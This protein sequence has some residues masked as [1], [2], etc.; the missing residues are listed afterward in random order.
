MKYLHVVFFLLVSNLMSA[1]IN[2]IFY[3]VDYSKKYDQTYLL[4]GRYMPEDKEVTLLVYAYKG[5]SKDESDLIAKR[6]V[7]L[8]VPLDS[9]KATHDSGKIHNLRTEF[10]TMSTLK[11]TKELTFI[12][13]YQLSLAAVKKIYVSKTQMSIELGDELFLLKRLNP[14]ETDNEEKE[15]K[16]KVRYYN[17]E[18]KKEI[19]I[20]DD[21][22]LSYFDDGK[23]VHTFKIKFITQDPATSLSE[24]IRRYKIIDSNKFTNVYIQKNNKV[25]KMALSGDYRDYLITIEANAS[26]EKIRNRFNKDESYSQE[27]SDNTTKQSNVDFSDG[28]HKFTSEKDNS[29]TLSITNDKIVL[30]SENDKMFL[31]LVVK[32]V[33]KFESTSNIFMRE[34][35]VVENEDYEYMKLL[36]LTSLTEDERE[37]L[38]KTRS[39]YAIVLYPKKDNE[40]KYT[41]IN[42]IYNG[43]K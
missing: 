24:N 11:K 15:I 32:L 28:Y 18:R 3:K 2:S 40:D 17:D 21:K 7:V 16:G 39:E 23:L 19:I 4:M 8:N 42:L 12:G 9:H 31:G 1:Q 43:K 27:K 5:D 38:L 33:K 37:K 14:D 41:F 6:K 13:D 29:I 10:S 25:S 35:D 26:E 36:D 22:K 34:Y 30:F 20:T